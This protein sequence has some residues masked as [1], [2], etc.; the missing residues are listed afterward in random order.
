MTKSN[1]WGNQ[2][3]GLQGSR[4]AQLV[5]MDMSVA[6]MNPDGPM[7][8]AYT[9]SSFANSISMLGAASVDFF[10]GLVKAYAEANNNAD[11]ADDADDLRGPQWGMLDGECYAIAVT[12]LFLQDITIDTLNE[13]CRGMDNFYSGAVANM[14]AS[15]NDSESGVMD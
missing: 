9:V 10:C 14:M 2:F 8:D 12:L 13:I 4:R 11:L 1:V 7:V 15:D 6:D 5:K 3:L